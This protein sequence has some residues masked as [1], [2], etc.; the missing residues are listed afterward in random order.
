MEEDK[1]TQ[2]AI[3]SSD[4]WLHSL[5]QIS[6]GRWRAETSC[7]RGSK[8]AETDQVNSTDCTAG[9]VL[10][11]LYCVATVLQPLY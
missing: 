4:C 3:F 8:F 7:V 11:A 9:T 2:V 10:Q 6:T 1:L 5:H